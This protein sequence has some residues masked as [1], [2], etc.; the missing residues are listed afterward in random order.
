MTQLFG[1]Y[2]AVGLLNSGIHWLVFLLLHWGLGQAQAVSN[3]G[4][5]CVAV[6]FSYI[7]NARF[8]FGVRPSGLRY[9]LFIGFMGLVSLLVGHSADRLTLS[10]LFTLV[11]YSTFSLVVGYLFSKFVVFRRA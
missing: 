9:V 4:A 1:R 5:F 6:S 7:T 11:L 2:F 8:T 10:P 3:L